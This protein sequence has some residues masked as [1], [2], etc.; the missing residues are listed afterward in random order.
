MGIIEP[1]FLWKQSLQQQR[2]NYI[3]K[4]WQKREK[5]EKGEK[6]KPNVK[7]QASKQKEKKEEEEE[8]ETDF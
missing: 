8:K 5:I 7:N 1:G 4:Q 6:L 2:P 3:K